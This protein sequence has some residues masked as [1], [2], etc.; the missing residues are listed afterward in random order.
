MT[1]NSIRTTAH[2]KAP[3]KSLDGNP[4]LVFLIGLEVEQLE[5][6]RQAGAVV[7]VGE[8]AA[9]QTLDRKRAHGH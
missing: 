6:G 3:D 1:N 8:N 9:E 5:L 4:I 2:H 7:K